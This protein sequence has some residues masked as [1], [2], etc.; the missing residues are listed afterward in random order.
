MLLR[1]LTP[2][3]FPLNKDASH[4][5][6]LQVPQVVARSHYLLSLPHT[7]RFLLLVFLLAL[8]AGM[9]VAT[10]L[11]PGASWPLG[12]WL[13]MASGMRVLVLEVVHGHACGAGGG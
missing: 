9:P 3:P 1:R 11:P 2:K 5:L 6:C 13:A 7:A 10:H 8:S 12:R 4:I